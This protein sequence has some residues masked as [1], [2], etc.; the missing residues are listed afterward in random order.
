MV[1]SM[2]TGYHSHS[3]A[4]L[5]LC[6][7]TVSIAS[8]ATITF[9][10]SE[11]TISQGATADYTMILDSAPDGLAG[12]NLNVVLSNPEIAEF[13]GITYPSWETLT[14]TTY[15]ATG[16]ARIS[17][18]D[19]GRMIQTGATQIILGTITI[20]GKSAGSTSIS[21][22]AVRM[23][24]DGGNAINPS[25]SNGV[26]IV[27]RSGGSTPGGGGGGSSYSGGGGGYTSSLSG[28]GITTTVQQ[29][30][31][32]AQ[33]ISIAVMST[34]VEPNAVGTPSQAA[35][36]VTSSPDVSITPTQALAASSSTGSSLPLGLIVGVIIVIGIIGA[37]LVLYY[38]KKGV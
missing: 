8:A 1:Q 2:K 33:D 22:N 9:E 25:V 28:A 6:I 13:A 14:N 17:G 20:Q 37:A 18:V 32:P 35:P 3:V 23:D 30:T 10:P 21:I 26:L 27:Q 38:V 31:T 16:I 7:L 15:P 24:A 19:I 12:Y 34:R 11:S 29:T 36:G 4:L 5:L